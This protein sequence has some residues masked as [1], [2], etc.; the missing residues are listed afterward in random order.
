[1]YN[2]RISRYI[3]A[4]SLLATV[5]C[6]C[7][8]GAASA[9]KEENTYLS[10]GEG[11]G[12]FSVDSEASPGEPAGSAMADMIPGFTSMEEE[13]VVEYEVPMIAPNILVDEMGYQQGEE[14]L[15][16]LRGRRL[17]SEFVVLDSVGGDEIYRGKVENITYNRELNLYEGRADFSTLDTVGSYF[18]H[19]DV[20]G[21]SQQIVIREKL[22]EDM[23]H[24]VCA[25]LIEAGDKEQLDLKEIAL[26]LQT[27][28][29]YPEAFADVNSN[30]VPDVLETVGKWLEG[31]DDA[32]LSPEETEWYILAL[33][34]YV[35]LGKEYQ[36]LSTALKAESVKEKA[37]KAEQFK[38][39]QGKAEKLGKELAA[40]KSEASVSGRNTKKGGAYWAYAELY[41]ITGEEVY[42]RKVKENVRIPENVQTSWEDLGYMLG[43]MTYL[44]TERWVDKKLCGA[45][46]DFVMARGEAV[47]AEHEQALLEQGEEGS[48][49][50]IVVQALELSCANYVIPSISYTNALKDYLHYLMGRNWEAENYYEEADDK[51]SYLLLLG[52]LLQ[53]PTVR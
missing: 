33:A 16:I 36:G 40:E 10:Q 17:P 46:M 35:C 25:H 3:V 44:A 31:M 1:M 20:I 51:G 26:L 41:R 8:E 49:T 27:V 18:L 48:E 21:Y 38:K 37:A 50:G 39:L 42:A 24:E 52:Q 53:E 19:C 47:C 45:Y 7:G 12:K 13:P 22:Y 34:K 15:A 6:G 23:F 4:V 2:K 14:K 29:W 11:N 32:E 9:W 28:E 43:S 30:Q 5:L